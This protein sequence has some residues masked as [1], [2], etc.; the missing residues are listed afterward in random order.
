MA[1]TLRNNFFQ[2]TSLGYEECVI[3]QAWWK[4]CKWNLRYSYKM[5]NG[6]D[7]KK[8]QMCPDNSKN[9]RRTNFRACSWL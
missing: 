1:Y 7:N 5:V 4:L 9:W 6:E 2:T 8:F 3:A